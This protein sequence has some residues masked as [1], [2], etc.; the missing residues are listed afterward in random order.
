M[1]WRS[2]SFVNKNSEEMQQSEEIYT[3]FFFHKKYSFVAIIYY[4]VPSF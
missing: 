2:K 3:H 4:F 1:G